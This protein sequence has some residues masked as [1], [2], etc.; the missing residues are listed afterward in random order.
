MYLLW[1][2]HHD[3]R[4]WHYYRI[5]QARLKSNFSE[6]GITVTKGQSLK[7]FKAVSEMWRHYRCQ[8]EVLKS[9]RSCWPLPFYLLESGP[10]SKKYFIKVIDDHWPKLFMHKCTQV[11]CLS[12]LLTQCQRFFFQLH[13][14]T[15]ILLTH[16]VCDFN[17]SV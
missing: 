15:H 1:D 3:K 17:L 11:F 6:T 5:W 16:A 8:V 7:T 4:K 9:K 12:S 10:T 2:K 14:Y 13:M